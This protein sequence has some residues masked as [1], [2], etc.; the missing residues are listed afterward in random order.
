MVAHLSA[1]WSGMG[2]VNKGITHRCIFF[3]FNDLPPA[4]T[5]KFP[6]KEIM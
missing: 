4:V 6:A 1:I 2:I 3:F 5:F